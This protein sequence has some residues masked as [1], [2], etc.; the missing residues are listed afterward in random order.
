MS[1][2]VSLRKQ[3]FATLEELKGSNPVDMERI[4]AKTEMYKVILDSA[5]VEVVYSKVV[6]RDVPTDFFRQE[7]A[8][9]KEQKHALPQPQGGLADFH[10]QI[11]HVTIHR[12]K[13]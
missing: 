3:M 9:A 12:M 4:K 11:G 13:G 8:T 7:A 6:G 2:L 5:K 10:S 1:D